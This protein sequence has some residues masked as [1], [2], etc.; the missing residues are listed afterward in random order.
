[1]LAWHV[2]EIVSLKELKTDKMSLKHVKERETENY[3]MFTYF[4]H[5]L[6]EGQEKP[7]FACQGVVILF[8]VS[9]FFTLEGAHLFAHFLR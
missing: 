9:V 1:M 3:Y 4:D 2:G 8:F 7:A 5:P 6:A